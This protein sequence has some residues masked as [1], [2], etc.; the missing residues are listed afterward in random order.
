MTANCPCAGVPLWT[1]AA[2][3]APGVAH[4]TR[5]IDALIF[6]SM[7]TRLEYRR[8]WY[9]DAAADW[10]ATRALP[11]ATYGYNRGRKMSATYQLKKAD[12]GLAE[13]TREYL[14]P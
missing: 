5:R 14:Q 6:R 3:G 12:R 2:C 10:V 13:L 8:A 4:E 9:A 7:C 1:C 11:P